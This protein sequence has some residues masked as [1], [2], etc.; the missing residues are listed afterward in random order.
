MSREQSE[1]S[2]LR[3]W[4]GHVR[5]GSPTDFI[6]SPSDFRSSSKFRHQSAEQAVGATA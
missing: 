5:I 3:Q 1:E 2:G 4:P 6:A